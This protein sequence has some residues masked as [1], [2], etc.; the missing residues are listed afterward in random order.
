MSISFA[1][2]PSGLSLAGD[3]LLNQTMEKI[4]AQ[5]DHLG[6][7]R[8]KPG[9][10]VTFKGK[11]YKIQCRTTLASGEAAVVLQGEREQFVISAN[12]FLAGVSS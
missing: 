1:G 5:S 9:V 11:P 4:D 12:Q 3:M 10:E 6:L 8:F 7:E 2:A